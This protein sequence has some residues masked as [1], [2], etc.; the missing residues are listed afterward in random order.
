M[1]EERKNTRDKLTDSAIIFT[2]NDHF[3]GEIQSGLQY[4]GGKNKKKAEMT[5]FFLVGHYSSS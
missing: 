2:E 1:S 4:V 5:T 3:A